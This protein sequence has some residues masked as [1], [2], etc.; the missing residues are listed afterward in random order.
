MKTEET[1]LIC[2]SPTRTSLRIGKAIARG[3]AAQRE[4][5][6]DLT[7]TI[8][9]QPTAPAPGTLAILAMP[10]YGGHI[11]PAAAERLKEIQGEQTPAILVAVYGNRDYENALREL[12]TLAREQGFLPVAAATFI[13]EHSYSTEQAPIAQG[14]PDKEDLEKAEAFGKAVREKLDRA[15]DPSR[16]TLKSTDNIP[17]PRQ[18]LLPRLGFIVDIV[19][20][21]RSGQP[22]PKTPAT[23]PGLCTHCGACVGLCPTEAIAA[24]DELNTDSKSCIR[25]CACVKGCPLG[26]RRFDTPFAHILTRRFPGRKEPQT[27]L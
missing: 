18:P 3:V 7:H 12:E 23:D 20:L 14:R 17:R 27:L 1:R 8:P 5:L 2:F 16:A 24:G 21:R 19:R 10:V 9:K 13:G 26:A 15:E 11:P 22:L 4:T 25:C 6:L